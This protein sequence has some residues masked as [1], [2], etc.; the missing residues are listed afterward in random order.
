MKAELLDDSLSRVVL[1]DCFVKAQLNDSV[2]AVEWKYAA[3]SCKTLI[4]PEFE[5]ALGRAA[6]VKFEHDHLSSDERKV[7]EIVQLLLASPAGIPKPKPAEPRRP[8]RRRREGEGR[9]PPGSEAR[10]APPPRPTARAGR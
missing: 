8:A 5:E 6:L 3:D 4:F 9:R 2:V 1:T 7:H 10:S